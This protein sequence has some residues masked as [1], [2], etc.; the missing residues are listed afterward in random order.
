MESTAALFNN[1]PMACSCKFSN[2]LRMSTVSL[3]IEN[4]SILFKIII[5][6][7]NFLS[8]TF[9][10]VFMVLQ[11]SVNIMMYNPRKWKFTDKIL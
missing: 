6:F 9:D 1:F 2:S 4:E 5:N 10:E 7:L 3:P 11:H 8:L